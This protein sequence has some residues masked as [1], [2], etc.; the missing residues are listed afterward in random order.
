MSRFTNRAGGSD[1]E[2]NSLTFIRPADLGRAEFR[3]VI[4]EGVFVGSLQNPRDEDKLDF[5]IEADTDLE[6]RG[7]D[8]EGN[9][10]LTSVKSG[11]TLVVNGAGNLGYLMK[12]VSPGTLCQINYLGKQPIKK[13]PRKGTE[14]HTFEVMYE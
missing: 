7:V 14:A 3:G 2:G 8:R 13:G 11:D 1:S 9:E 6:I 4:A 10:I 5:K 12:E